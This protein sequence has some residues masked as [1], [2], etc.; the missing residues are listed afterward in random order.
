MY[1][2]FT[3]VEVPKKYEKKV[4]NAM[5]KNRIKGRKINI[6]VAKSR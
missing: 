3:F 1:D 4:L 5:D 2:K 6:E